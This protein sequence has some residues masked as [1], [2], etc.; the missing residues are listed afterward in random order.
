MIASKV[1][2][3]DFQ[4]PSIKSPPAK[5]PFSTTLC[6]AYYRIIQEKLCKIYTSPLAFFSSFT[7]ALA[8]IP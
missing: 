8:F 2:N 1:A 7:N 6:Q 5:S 3:V 4:N